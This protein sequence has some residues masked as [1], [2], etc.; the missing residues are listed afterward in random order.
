[1]LELLDEAMVVRVVS[2]VRVA[3]S[4]SLR[5]RP[6]PRHALR[7]SRPRVV[8]C[9]TGRPPRRSRRSTVPNRDPHGGLAY[10]S[11]AG[12]HYTQGR[13]LRRRAGDRA[14]ASSRTR[15]SCGWGR[16]PRG[17]RPLGPV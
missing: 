7:G 8:S 14:F 9:C 4:S 2:D 13:R 15:A 16:V 12:G 6:H 11:I 3:W 5:P 17:T 1:L 10:H